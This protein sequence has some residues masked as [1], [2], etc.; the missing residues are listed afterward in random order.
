MKAAGF[1]IFLNIV[2]LCD[3]EIHCISHCFR[4]HCQGHFGNNTRK[5]CRARGVHTRQVNCRTLESVVNK[6]KKSRHKSI[7][8]TTV[9]WLN[10]DCIWDAHVYYIHGLYAAYS[11]DFIDKDVW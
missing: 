5:E 3:K 6:T 4:R 2:T 8:T 10:H 7:L 9:V 11:A 1:N